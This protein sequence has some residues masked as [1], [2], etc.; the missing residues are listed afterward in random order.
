MMYVLRM[1]LIFFATSLLADS[2]HLMLYFD[3]NKTLIASDKAGGKTVENVINEL[4]GEKYEAVWDYEHP[5]KMTFE[6]YVHQVL[7]PGPEKD[8]ALRTQ[9]R[10]Y[11]HHFVE[12]LKE[13]AHPLYQEVLEEYEVALESLRASPGT[14]FNSFYLLLEDLDQRGISYS[15]ILRS[16]GDEVYEVKNEIEVIREMPISQVGK[17][18]VGKLY[19]DG[20]VPIAGSYEIY[21]QLRYQG[22]TAL[23]DDWEDWRAHGET[24]KHG[25]PFYLDREDGET[26]ALFFDDNIHEDDSIKNIIAPTDARSG[27]FIPVKSLIETGQAVSVDA[28]EVILNNNYFIN[29]VNEALDKHSAMESK[30]QAI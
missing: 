9:K 18:R 16:F 6:E 11:L 12:Y 1:V 30:F 14:V 28:L 15:I 27:E 5:E 7:V 26:L 22:H 13:R 3:I 23:N 8:P 20:H 4:L 17:I 21:Q 10:A 19:L 24:A 2:P 25:K 29:K